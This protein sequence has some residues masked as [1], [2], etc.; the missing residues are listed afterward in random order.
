MNLINQKMKD[1]QI[2]EFIKKYTDGEAMAMALIF[3]NGV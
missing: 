3:F 1:C 2:L